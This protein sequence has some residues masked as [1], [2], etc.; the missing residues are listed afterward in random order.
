MAAPALALLGFGLVSLPVIDRLSA[1]DRTVDPLA[2][3]LV[4]VAAAAL[5]WRDRWPRLV[6]AVTAT[7]TSVYLG[8]GYPYGPIMFCLAVAV[9]T[10]AWQLPSV[11]SAGWCG[12]TLLALLVHVVTGAVALPDLLGIVPAS[13]WVVLPA[14]AGVARR[15]VLL[16]RQREQAERESRLLAAERLRMAHDVHDIVGHGL[17]AMRMQA[18][19]ALHLR[20]TRPEQAYEA[21]EAISRSSA[22]AL[23]ELRSALG[24]VSP[25]V[26]G[27]ADSQTGEEN[28]GPGPAP[29][30]GLAELTGLRDRMAAAGISVEVTVTGSPVPLPAPLDVTAYRVLQESLTN[31]ARHAFGVAAQVSLSYDDECLHLRVVNRVAASDRELEP[32]RTRPRPAAHGGGNGLG[33]AGMHRRVQQAGGSLTVRSSGH[34]PSFTVHAVLPLTDGAAGR[35]QLSSPGY[36]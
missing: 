23:A 36:G 5:F 20:R 17:A 30:P 35:P 32:G 3:V 18:D 33:L 29:G 6:L 21:L 8:I 24:A 12:A 19:I 25:G 11:Q 27:P 14:T 10:V 22:D 16:A 28:S 15:L 31:V 7:C 1:D 26:P 2:L 9:Y 13:A 4:V 34:P